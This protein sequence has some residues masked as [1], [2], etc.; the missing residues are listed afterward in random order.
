MSGPHYRLKGMRYALLGGMAAIL[1]LGFWFGGRILGLAGKSA[2]EEPAAPPSFIMQ[3]ERIVIPEGSALRSRLKIEP[4]TVKNSPHVLHLPGVVEADPARTINILPAVA[5][6]VVKLNIQL[7]DQV[8]KDQPLAVIDSGDLAMAY[9]DDDKA[10]SALKRAKFGL[11]RARGVHESGGGPQKDVE[12]AENDYEQAEA[13]FNRAEARLKEIGV[14]SVAKD[15]SRLLT[16][17]APITGSV[18]SLTTGS[19]AFANDPTVSLMTVSNLDSVWVTAMAPENS[20]SSIFKGQSVEVSFPAYPNQVL[21][22]S[23]SFISAVVEPD[24]RRTR[25]RIA[26]EN[27]EGKLKPNMFANVKFEIPQN[28]AVFVPDSALL[29]NN[30]KTTVLLEVAPWT[31]IRRPVVPGYGESDGT[32]IDQ[33]LSPGDRVVIRGGVL[34]N[35]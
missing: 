32:R 11:E 15:K 18:T 2:A 31:L 6:K 20:I 1:A 12:Q 14:S 7:G 29:M 21:R 34:F 13:E 26:F 4:V 16:I 23:V 9:A 17:V 30:D 19:G 24:T 5:G 25:V 35:D 33:G 28:S 22:G 27:P 3:E 8:K 10:R